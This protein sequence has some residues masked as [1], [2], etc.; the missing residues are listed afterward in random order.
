MKLVPG[1]GT[2]NHSLKPIGKVLIATPC[3]SGEVAIEF[4][5]AL[6]ETQGLMQSVG[7]Q[8]DFT[9]VRGD[10]FIGKA[11]N[12]LVNKFLEMGHESLFFID[13]D[14]GWDAQS[15]LRMVLDPH[16]IVAG[17]VPKKMDETTFNN[18]DL[19]TTGN[20]DCVIEGGL[21]QARKVGTGFMR[22]KRSAIE[23][24]I[25]AYPEQYLPGDGS[26][27]KHYRLFEVTIED[28]QFWGEDLKFCRKWNDIGGSVWIDPNVN[29]SHVGRKAWEGNFLKYLQEHCKVEISDPARKAA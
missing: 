1:L 27:G 12:N 24:L 19:V 3:L 22:V 21:L 10:C 11:R 15:F 26:P 28:G 4:V 5:V 14:E 25:A 2:E 6:M 13:A 17:A 18:V 7:I 23:K 8:V 29:F 16:E 20:A 9:S